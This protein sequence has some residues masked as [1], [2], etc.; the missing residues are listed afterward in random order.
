MACKCGGA[1]KPNMDKLKT[2][3]GTTAAITVAGLMF[4]TPTGW[5]ALLLGGAWTPEVIKMLRLKT[6]AA[7]LSHE[8]GG[9]FECDGCGRDV[10]IGEALGF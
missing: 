1:I 10:S 8:A 3:A 6:Q 7:K 4:G 9:Y 5:L 2:V